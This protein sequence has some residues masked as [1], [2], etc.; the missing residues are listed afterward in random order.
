MPGLTPF[1][2]LGPFFD[3]GLIIPGGEIV[4]GAEADGHHVTIEG[5]VRDSEGVSLPD[6]LIEV[7]QAD[8]SG[9]YR[10]PG[11]TDHGN[12]GEGFQGFGRVATD[13]D[14]RFRFRTVV[15]GRVDGPGG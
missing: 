12:S 9:N 14:G 10:R 13:D 15:P 3:F 4:A 5:A 2:T 6:A 7:W 8:A 11:D 1:Q